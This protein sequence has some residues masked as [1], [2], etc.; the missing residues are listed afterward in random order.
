MSYVNVE[1]MIERTEDARKLADGISIDGI[2]NY[3]NK[4]SVDVCRIPK[5]FI[6]D[7][8]GGI[9]KVIYELNNSPKLHN[10]LDD[11][12]NYI[13]YRY[14]NLYSKS[15]LYIHQYSYDKRINKTVYMITA[16]RSKNCDYIKEFGSPQFVSYLIEV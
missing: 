13:V 4:A 8:G 12:L 7:N 9:D 10:T 14:N 2:I 5:Y 11:V 6:Y 1:S 15:D 16:T 3:L